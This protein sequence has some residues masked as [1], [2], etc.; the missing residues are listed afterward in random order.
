MYKRWKILAC[1]FIILT[2]FVCGRLCLLENTT[3][4]VALILRFPVPS[5]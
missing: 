1:G 5:Q 3:L 2:L 4:D